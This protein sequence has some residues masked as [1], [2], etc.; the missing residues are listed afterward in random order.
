VLGVKAIPT[1]LNNSCQKVLINRPSLSLTMVLGKP[2][3]LKIS[4]RNKS[5]TCVALKSLAMEKKCA[6]LVN[7]STTTKIQSFS[8]ALGNPMM[9]SIEMLSHLCSGMGRGCNNPVGCVCSSF[10][11]WQVVHSLM[12]HITSYFIP[13]PYLPVCFDKSLVP[14]TGES[15]HACNTLALKDDSGTKKIRPL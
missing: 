11:T 5:A 1:N 14:S 10:F 8:C 7:L 3:S 12:W 15:W 9:K 2:C 13:F 4:L 6:N